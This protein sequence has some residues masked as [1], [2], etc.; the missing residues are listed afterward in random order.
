[1]RSRLTFSLLFFFHTI[2]LFG[3][4]SRIAGKVIDEI[5]GQPLQDVHI[6][7]PNTT[8]QAFSDS[9]GGFLISNVPEGKWEVQVWG[10][11]WETHREEL[12]LKAGILKNMA[13]KLVQNSGLDPVAETLS[14]GQQTK[15][16]DQLLEI[17]VGADFKKK[18][19]AV[20]NPDKFIFEKLQDKNFRVHSIGP[21]FFSNNESGYLV[22]TYFKPFILGSSDKIQATYSYFELPSD[23]GQMPLWRQQRMKIYAQSPQKFLSEL[24][25]GSSESF[26]ADPNPEVSFADHSGDY[27]LSFTKPLSVNLPEG[28]KGELNYR[29]EKLEVKFNGAPVSP[30]HLVLGGAFLDLNPIFELPT[31]FNAEKLIKLANLEK[32]T[33]TMQERIFVHTD[34]KHYWPGENLYFKAYLNYGNPLM[35]EDLS[36]VLHVELLDSTGYLWMHRVFKINGGV[37][38]GHLELPASQDPGNFILRAYTAW[39]QN[40]S[41]GDFFQPVQIL[42]HQSQPESTE[43]QQNA[44]GVGVFSDKQVYDGGEKVKLNIMAT[45]ASGNPVNANLSVTVLDLNQA[46]A[47]PEAKSMEESFQSKVAKRP[48]EEFPKHPENGFSLQGQLLNIGGQAVSGSLKAFINGY[49]DVRSLGTDKSGN[50]ELPSSNFDGQFEIAVQATDKDARPVRNVSLEIINYPA[51]LISK[52]FDYPAVVSRGI[53]PSPDIQPL[54]DLEMGEILMEEAVIEDK[55]EPSIGPMIYGRPDNVVKTEDIFLN[56]TTIQ[57]LYALA[58]Q[59]PGMTVFGTPPAIRFRGGEPLVLVNGSPMNSAGLSGLGGGGSGGQTAFDVISNLNVFSIERVEVIRRLVPQY[60]DLGRNGIISIILKTGLDLS[61]AVEANMNNYTIFKLNGYPQIQSFEELEKSR[62][63]FPFLTEHKPTLYWNP[64]L[65]AEESRMSQ[66][67]EFQL[68]EKSGPIWVEI[69]GITDLGEPIFGSFLLNDP[70]RG[71][72]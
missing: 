49:T 58:G 27:L 46:V 40:Y 35:A 2:I 56:G 32:T 41:D 48:I 26:D 72:K 51:E 53:Q 70:S 10:H 34:R 54:R 39:G 29:G 20:L 44:V 1:M 24:M 57:F 33:E 21:I 47:I 52:S 38:S 12:V 71:G 19:V 65:R 64:N 43:L 6:F 16:I 36:K 68:N 22:S 9:L 4:T 45:N 67:I 60:G 50:F 59:I 28:K 61:K 17:F 25:T 63:E 13:I 7:I 42:G 15:V 5:T 30:E 3:Q 55:R 62:S 23:G 69:R 14:K 37:S 11:G 8:F 18:E 31:N 66:R